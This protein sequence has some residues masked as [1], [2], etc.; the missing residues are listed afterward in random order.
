MEYTTV[1]IYSLFV[2]T[3]KF[4]KRKKEGDVDLCA[5]VPHFVYEKTKPFL[6]LKYRKIWNEYANCFFT[7]KELQLF[8][9]YEYLFRDDVFVINIDSKD[10]RNISKILSEEQYEKDKMFLTELNK[11]IGYEDIKGFFRFD[12]KGEN[13]IYKLT[14][15]KTI[16]PMMYIKFVDEIENNENE[17]HKRFTKIIKKIK[18]LLTE[19]RTN[20]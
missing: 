8:L 7:F 6:K 11:K 13:V 14:K 1:D 12:D 3:R 15:K 20:G 2:N 9:L 18:Q 19:K 17:E 5:P 4:I 10:V 16:S